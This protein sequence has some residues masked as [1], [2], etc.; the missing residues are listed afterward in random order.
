MVIRAVVFDVGGVLKLPLDTDWNQKWNARL[1]LQPEELWARLHAV[2]C[3]GILGTCT[4]AEWLD[5]L[6]QVTGVDQAQIDEYMAD[7]WADYLGRHNAELSAYFGSLRPRFQTAILSNSFLGAREKEQA[8][9]GFEDLCDFII[10]SHEVGIAK[11]DPRIFAL[12]CERLKLAPS[13][14]IFVDDVEAYVA[15]ARALGIHAI[16]FRDNAQVIAEIEAC[17]QTNAG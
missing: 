11:P 12:T 5:G 15:A 10:Y 8:A 14:V 13:E 6:R 9:Y 1:N 2:G 4:A 16:Q 7:L 3:N 17:I